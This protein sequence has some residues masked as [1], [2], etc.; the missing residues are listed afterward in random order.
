LVEDN[1]QHFELRGFFPSLYDEDGN[2]WN[3]SQ[4]YYLF[5]EM[6][7]E[8]NS[9]SDRTLSFKFIDSKSRADNTSSIYEDLIQFVNDREVYPDLVGF[10]VVDEEDRYNTLL[11]YVEDFL[12]I[13]NYTQMNGLPPVKFFFH[14]GETDWANKD[15]LYDAI[16]LNTTRIGHAYSLKDY[17]LLKQIVKEKEIALEL[18]PI[19]NQMLRLVS[20]I[21]NHPG[22]IYAN[23]GLPITLN[24]DDPYIYGNYGL[25]YD[26]YEAYMSWNLE[27]SGLK[28][29]AYNSIK[30]SQLNPHE[31]EDAMKDWE[32]RWDIWIKSVVYEYL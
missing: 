30:F 1:I 14:G 12:S 23:E 2:I 25:S 27:L 20:D 24:N 8:F 10:D 18:C 21:R 5:H 6:L 4:V 13:Q 28:Q 19:S 15:N 31:M 17:P 22:A 16:L 11:Y 3:A 29:L 32:N 26:F 7:N 9:I